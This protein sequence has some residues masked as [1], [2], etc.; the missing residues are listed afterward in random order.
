MLKALCSWLCCEHGIL[1]LHTTSLDAH[2]ITES[3]AS[4]SCK[5]HFR[6]GKAVAEKNNNK[7]AALLSRLLSTVVHCHSHAVQVGRVF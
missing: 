2:G 1:V 3:M 5:K 6:L 4:W 7:P